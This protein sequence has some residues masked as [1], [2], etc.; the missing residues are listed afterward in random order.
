MT[1]EQMVIYANLKVKLFIQESFD[2]LSK[3]IKEEFEQARNS[4]TIDTK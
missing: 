2:N 1:L 3:E 4:L